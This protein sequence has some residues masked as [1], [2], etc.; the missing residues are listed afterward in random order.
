ERLVLQAELAERDRRAAEAVGLDR[1]SAGGEIAAVDLAHQVGT[2]LGEDLGA[3]FVA[4][5][6]LLDTQIAHLHLRPHG[7]VAEQH[8]IGEKIEKMGHVLCRL[9]PILWRRGWS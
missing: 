9:L 4:E 5:E 2:A 7:A 8:A 6:I 3:V 1:V